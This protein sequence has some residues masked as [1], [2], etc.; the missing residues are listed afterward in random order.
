MSGCRLNCDFGFEVGRHDGCQLCECRCV[1]EQ[2]YI[3]SKKNYLVYS[4]IGQFKSRF[5]DKSC[6]NGF[7]K[8]I[9]GCFTCYCKQP[10]VEYPSYEITSPVFVPSSFNLLTTK[11]ESS[12]PIN[13]LRFSTTPKIPRTLSQS[14]S[15]VKSILNNKN[16]DLC[17]VSC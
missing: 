8:D 4:K 12:P 15:R 1:N 9:Y 16:E 14:K 13:H 2:N 3:E 11:K 17:D 6:S 10:K 7:V 5:C